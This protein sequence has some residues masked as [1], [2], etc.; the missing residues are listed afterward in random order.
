MAPPSH[1][2]TT[3]TAITITTTLLLALLLAL[4]LPSPDDTLVLAQGDHDPP[5][6]GSPD[7]S[8]CGQSGTCAQRRVAAADTSDLYVKGVPSVFFLQFLYVNSTAPS[9]T[10]STTSASYNAVKT[11]AFYP[12]VDQYSELV[13]PGSFALVRGTTSAT[14]APYVQVL[15]YFRGQLFKSGPVAWSKLDGDLYYVPARTVVV[16]LQNGV[17]ISATSLAWSPTDCAL[18]ACTCIDNIC[19]STCSA[20]ASCDIKVRVG[21]AGTDGNGNILSSSSLDIWRFQNAF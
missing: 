17:P 18:S 3:T 4:I 20:A 16:N 13:V 11:A 5:S 15:L 2:T 8:Y 1:T 12:L 21:W 7:G 6:W 9:T 19:G 14:V 10:S